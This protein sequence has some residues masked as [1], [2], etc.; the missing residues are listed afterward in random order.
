MDLLIVGAG[1]VGRWFAR[2]LRA[3]GAD[4]GTPAFAD[5]DPDVARGAADALD[6]RAIA[7][8]ED[9][10]FARESADSDSREFD[11]VCVAVPIPAVESALAA[12]A[13]R[14][15]EAVCDVA[16]VME[17][18]VAAA[19]EHAPDSERLSL[20]PL[21]APE[22]APGNVAAVPDRPG[23]TT[24][25]IR[26]ALSAAGNDVFETTPAEHDRAM[27]TV[28]ARTHAA[29]LAFALAADPV[30]D[31]FRTPAYDRMAA[32][33]ETVTGGDPRV[34]ADIQAAFA[35]AEDVA[36]AARRVAAA[37]GEAFRELYREASEGTKDDD[38]T[39]SGWEDDGDPAASGRRDDGD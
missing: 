9:G 38:R 34:Y 8:D 23:P 32:L 2:A 33:V 16:G 37:D 20:H 3:G 4:L 36:D 30:P 26:A 13:H 17:P 5:V 1:D 39:A 15:S 14:A 18:A 12:H 22:N 11:A 31:R 19:R 7:L 6:G 35:G 28:Q 29:A 21:F 10:T 24:D 25:R 27:E